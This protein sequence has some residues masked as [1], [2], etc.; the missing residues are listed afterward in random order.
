MGPQILAMVPMEDIIIRENMAVSED[1]L[2][3]TTSCLMIYG[4]PLSMDFKAMRTIVS[5][6][7]MQVHL[8]VHHIFRTSIRRNQSFWLETESVSQA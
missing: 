6:L 8:S 5:N 2:E 7:T 1:P 3:F 4:I